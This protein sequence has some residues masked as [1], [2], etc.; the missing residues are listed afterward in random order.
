MY[1]RLLDFLRCPECG[2]TL[3]LVPLVPRTAA[4]PDEI[5]EGLLRCANEHWFPVVRG[6]PRMLPDSL[7]EHWPAL[8]ALIP[9]PPPLDLQQLVMMHGRRSRETE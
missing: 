2:D 7:E 5:S 3:E 6:I 8:E 1:L 9:N 4:G